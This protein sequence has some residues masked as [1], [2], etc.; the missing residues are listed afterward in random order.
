MLIW[1]SIASSSPSELE[2]EDPQDGAT[3]VHEELGGEQV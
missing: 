3:V 2:A 1:P